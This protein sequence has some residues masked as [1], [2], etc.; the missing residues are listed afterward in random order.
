M[1]GKSHAC[2]SK[3]V[4]ERLLSCCRLVAFVCANG[5]RRKNADKRN[6]MCNNN[7]KPSCEHKNRSKRSL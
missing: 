4:I 3:T 6:S 7:L 2:F 5:K 1:V